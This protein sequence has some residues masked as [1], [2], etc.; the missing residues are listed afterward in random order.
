MGTKP[1]FGKE[2]KTTIQAIQGRPRVPT[3]GQVR[4][5]GQIIK[6]ERVKGFR[7]QKDAGCETSSLRRTKFF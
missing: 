4:N 1:L 3:E 2:Q 5:I 6:G 7:F